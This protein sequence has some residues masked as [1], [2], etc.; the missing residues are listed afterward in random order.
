MNA[1]FNRT[2]IKRERER[3]LEQITPS[4]I[5]AFSLFR[6]SKPN[7]SSLGTQTGSNPKAN[8]SQFEDPA[9]HLVYPLKQ[10][11]PWTSL[12]SH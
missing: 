3:E 6:N 1:M 9:I 7:N 2:G 11:G 4:F 12:I 5:S 8:Q 10:V